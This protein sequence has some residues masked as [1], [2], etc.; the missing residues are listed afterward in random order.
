MPSP[1]FSRGGAY[2][3]DDYVSRGTRCKA[4]ARRK[5]LD[6]NTWLALHAHYATDG[7]P[8]C[9]CFLMGARLRTGRGGQ[10]SPVVLCARD[11]HLTR[12]RRGPTFVGPYNSARTV[13][14][15]MM[16]RDAS[17]VEAKTLQRKTRS[18]C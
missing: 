15:L 12:V 5:F 6:C 9:G 18:D 1:G 3:A 7:V 4:R 8:R 17:N 11:E 10:R 2:F 14:R 13:A 16:L